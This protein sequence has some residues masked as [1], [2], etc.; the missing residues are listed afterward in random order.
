MIVDLIN[1]GKKYNKMR[2]TK[3]KIIR[4]ANPLRKASNVVLINVPL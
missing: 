2:Q 4:M 3:I 1:G